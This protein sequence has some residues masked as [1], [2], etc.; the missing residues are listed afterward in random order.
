MHFSL[1][2]KSDVTFFLLG[3]SLSLNRLSDASI[4]VCCVWA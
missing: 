4:A 3:G 2:S 1:S